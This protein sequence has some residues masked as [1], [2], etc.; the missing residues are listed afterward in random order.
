MQLFYPYTVHEKVKVKI[1]VI[2]WA[3]GLGKVNYSSEN[4]DVIIFSNFY[5]VIKVTKDFARKINIV[6][7]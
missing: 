3:S 5:D 2:L 4:K 6:Y 7:P 1:L